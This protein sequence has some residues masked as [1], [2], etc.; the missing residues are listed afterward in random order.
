LIEGHHGSHLCGE[1]LSL[2]YLAIVHE[3]KSDHQ[4]EQACTMCLEAREDES[5]RSPEFSDAVLCRRCVKQS[6]TALEK[7]K[8]YTWKRP[9]A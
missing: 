8:D 2:A 9:S 6:A 5:W 7:D 4:P 1:C 3:G